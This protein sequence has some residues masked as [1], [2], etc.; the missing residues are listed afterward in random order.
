MAKALR[1]FNLSF[2]D[3]CLS[4]EAY[5]L[6]GIARMAV[7]VLP[8]RWIASRL[9]EQIPIDA[10]DV[11]S[12][13]I[14]NAKLRRIG[15]A[16]RRAGRYTPWKSNCLAK[17]IAGQFML[18]RRRIGN[19]VYFGVF[20]INGEFEAHAWLRS[21]E[22]ILSGGGDLDRYTIVAKFIN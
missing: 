22:M 18:R 9:G 2:S 12:D 16:I 15:R 8:F 10:A 14:S 7:L 20:K 13:T 17:A 21:G 6:L 11:E 3:K 1:I 5:F 4:L 19:T